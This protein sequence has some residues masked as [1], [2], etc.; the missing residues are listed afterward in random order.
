MPTVVIDYISLVDRT[1]PTYQGQLHTPLL[2]FDLSLAKIE[3]NNYY[4]NLLR[5]QLLQLESET[6][7]VETFAIFMV[8]LSFGLNLLNC[9]YHSR[10][11]IPHIT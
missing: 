1:I 10:R 5:V 11:V 7:Y 4:S 9:F 3:P 2:D 6:C 8:V